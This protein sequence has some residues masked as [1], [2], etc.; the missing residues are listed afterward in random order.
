M[1]ASLIREARQGLVFGI[2]A[3]TQKL[4]VPFFGYG[5]SE[6]V[7]KVIHKFNVIGTRIIVAVS[8]AFKIAQCL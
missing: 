8:G 3:P 5:N 6:L 2:V 7:R 1:F 4:R